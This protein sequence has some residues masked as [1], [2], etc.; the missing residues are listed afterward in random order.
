MH[1][2]LALCNLYLYSSTANN[3]ESREDGKV[4][5]MTKILRSL[6]KKH[7]CSLDLAK[8]AVIATNCEDIDSCTDWIVINRNNKK[9]IEENSTKF[10]QEIGRLYITDIL[11]SACFLYS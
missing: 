5:K 9:L 3:N 8:A 2:I 10:D 11:Y 4:S 6:L 1:I 7:T